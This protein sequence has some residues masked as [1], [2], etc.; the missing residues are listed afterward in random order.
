MEN[1]FWEVIQWLYIWKDIDIDL[2]IDMHMNINLDIYIYIYIRYRYKKRDIPE[3]TASNHLS[4]PDSCPNLPM[5]CPQLMNPLFYDC[6]T[7]ICCKKFSPSRVKVTFWTQRDGGDGASG[8]IFGGVRHLAHML[9]DPMAENTDSHLKTNLG[10]IH[11]TENID[12]DI[13]HFCSFLCSITAISNMMFESIN[14]T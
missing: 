14:L 6:L 5:L 10:T 13:C 4:Q 8:L 3:K 11:P 1:Q 9:I 7:C 12:I 2:D